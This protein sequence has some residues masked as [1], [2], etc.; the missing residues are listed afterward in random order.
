MYGPSV[1][2]KDGIRILQLIADEPGLVGI[3]AGF[4]IGRVIFKWNNG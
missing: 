4:A 2:V 1:P 3:T